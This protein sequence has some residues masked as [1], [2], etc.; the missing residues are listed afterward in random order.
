MSI[1]DYSTSYFLGREWSNTPLY[2][3]KIVPLLDY[4]LSNNFVYSNKLSGAFYELINKYQNTSELP[5]ASLKELVKEM[6][7]EYILNLLADDEEVIKILVYLLVLIHQLKGSKKGLELVMSLFSY[8]G[9]DRI[10]ILIKEWFKQI[11]INNDEADVLYWFKQIPTNEEGMS[12]WL[13][14]IISTE[15]NVLYQEWIINIPIGGTNTEI[16]DWYQSIPDTY[17]DF[18]YWIDGL[19]FQTGYKIVQWFEENAYTEDGENVNPIDGANTVVGEENTFSMDIQVDANKVNPDFFDNFNTFIHSYVYPE[20]KKLR[21]R[22][23]VKAEM[24]Y[25]TYSRINE[26]FQARGYVTG[27]DDNVDEKDVIINDKL[28]SVDNKCTWTIPNT[29]FKDKNVIVHIIDIFS[30]RVQLADIIQ[31]DENIIV[32]IDSSEDINENT[33]VAIVLQGSEDEELDVTRKF[34]EK[35]VLLES[36]DGECTWEVTNPFNTKYIVT[37]VLNTATGQQQMCDIIQSNDKIFIYIDSDED[38]PANTLTL[39]V[40]A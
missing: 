6:G 38:I 39:I 31:T 15:Q 12:N 14:S 3:Q 17:D 13:S 40:L 37:S 24:N 32:N 35:N 26:F 22:T 23:N 27:F 34:V 11:P 9:G 20:L 25:I 8:S 1:L 19:N 33:L 5:L 29:K 2:A 7:Y 16:Y 21:V 36:L 4:I 10:N 18:I 28:I 30:G